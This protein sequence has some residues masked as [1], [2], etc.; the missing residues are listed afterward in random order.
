MSE[1]KISK[2]IKN[3]EASILQAQENYKKKKEQAIVDY[4][5]IISQA[6]KDLLDATIPQEDE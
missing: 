2:A 1:E 4:A 5:E 6:F 3:L